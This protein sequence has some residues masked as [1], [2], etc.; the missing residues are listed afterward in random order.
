MYSI[1][2]ELSVYSFSL[3]HR[4]KQGVVYSHFWETFSQKYKFIKYCNGIR[5][6][7]PAKIIN[8]F[9]NSMKFVWYLKPN[10]KFIEKCDGIHKIFSGV[11]ILKTKTLKTK[12]EDVKEMTKCRCWLRLSGV[13]PNFYVCVFGILYIFIY[14]NTAQCCTIPFNHPK[15]I[16]KIVV[17]VSEPMM[18]LFVHENECFVCTRNVFRIM[19]CIVCPC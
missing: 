7:H 4:V 6:I 12:K 1:L 9:K 18:I 14:S 15:N 17:L 19:I 2:N 3:P 8:L 16:M 13:Y 10:E 11:K 5:G